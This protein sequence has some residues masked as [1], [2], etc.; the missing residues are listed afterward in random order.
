M[1]P[2]E[3]YLGLKENPLVMEIVLLC[4]RTT[5]QTTESL[6]TYLGLKK[7]ADIYAKVPVLL[8]A[9]A[10]RVYITQVIPIHLTY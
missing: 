8:T 7:G 2:K 3:S 6:M 9:L 4:T 10:R 5:K 1:L